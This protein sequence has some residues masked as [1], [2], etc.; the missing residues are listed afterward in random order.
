MTF[1]KRN[2]RARADTKQERKE[3]RGGDGGG[4]KKQLIS[5]NDAA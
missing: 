3:R 4:G 5:V 2:P 1:F